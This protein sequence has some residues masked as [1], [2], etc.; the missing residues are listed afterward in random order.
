[1]VRLMCWGDNK[2]ICTLCNLSSATRT[3]RHRTFKTLIDFFVCDYC[4]RHKI[5]KLSE[6]LIQKGW[7]VDESLQQNNPIQETKNISQV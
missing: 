6:I 7:K 5:P 1:M 4:Y 2:M 3:I